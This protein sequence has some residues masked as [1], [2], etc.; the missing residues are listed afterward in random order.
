MPGLPSVCLPWLSSDGLPWVGGANGALQNLEVGMSPGVPAGS[1]KRYE[2]G[3]A[4]FQ[5]R[6]D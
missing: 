6:L 1:W 2:G 4:C 5:S 3:L